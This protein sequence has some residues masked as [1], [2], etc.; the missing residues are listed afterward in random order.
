MA[1][2]RPPPI[3]GLPAELVRE[4][5]RL[6]CADCGEIVL[7]FTQSNQPA[8]CASQFCRRWR[9]VAHS[10][11]ALWR[12]FRVDLPDD[13]TDGQ[14]E[15]L[16]NFIAN[17]ALSNETALVLR[18][19]AYRPPQLNPLLPIV[20]SYA[21][22]IRSLSLNMP[23]QAVG[24]IL[25]TAAF[26]FYHL[27]TLAVAIRVAEDNDVLFLDT[28]EEY[29]SKIFTDS[30]LLTRVT[31]G[32][33]LL[34]PIT[35]KTFPLDAWNLPWSQ[36]TEFRAPNVWIDAMQ[37]FTLVESCPNL[38]GCELTVDAE[39]ADD[40]ENDDARITLAYLHKFHIKF[41]ELYGWVWSNLT[42]PSLVDLKIATFRDENLWEDD[43][44]DAF[45]AR[46]VCG[47]THLALCFGFLDTID[48]MLRILDAAPNLEELML[49]WTRLPG[50]EEEDWDVTPLMDYLSGSRLPSLRRIQIDATPESVGMLLS[51]CHTPGSVLN[52]VVLCAVQPSSCE[53]LFAVEIDAMRVAGM[54]VVCE[55]I[56]FPLKQIYDPNYRDDTS[57]EGE[58][59]PPLSE[60][61][62]PEGYPLT[63]IPTSTGEEQASGRVA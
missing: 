62:E 40:P 59:S 17:G 58:D 49:C 7:P 52:E 24:E 6:C 21:R 8:V 37:F 55:A 39:G 33:D 42:M 5:V 61:S 11:G 35:M 47:L 54:L 14:Y 56:E 9:A 31:I 16:M 51:R 34:M 12:E 60:D 27:Q 3:H 10:E 4:I 63:G 13:L 43:V 46:S 2:P 48:A 26:P 28:P 1:L 15:A 19:G 22:S 44:F 32:Y 38:V 29:V 57:D 23:G 41:L 53:A 50:I 18:Q 20:V 30:P 45:M 36:L 25:T